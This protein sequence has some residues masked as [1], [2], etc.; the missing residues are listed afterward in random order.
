VSVENP[1]V[2]DVTVE[3]T[4]IV[5][6]SVAVTDTYVERDVR[7]DV[8]TTGATVTVVE[9]LMKLAEDTTVTV[10]AGK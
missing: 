8:T 6:P 5:E 2:D 4:E 7:L 1:V 3:P 9:L 10:P